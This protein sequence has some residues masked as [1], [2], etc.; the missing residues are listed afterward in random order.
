[1]EYSFFSVALAREP[2]VIFI[3]YKTRRGLR[4]APDLSLGAYFGVSELIVVRSCEMKNR[5]L[6][7]L[8]FSGALVLG[9]GSTIAQ[10]ANS[11]VG[12]SQAGANQN[13]QDNADQDID[14]LRK[15]IRYQKR[16]LIATNVP[17]TEAE[18]K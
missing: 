1:M 3:P 10:N 15:D 7:V 14:M 12:S 2:Q 11:Q 17:L 16:Q 13:S 9:H 6:A 4:I 8:L 18:A 5:L